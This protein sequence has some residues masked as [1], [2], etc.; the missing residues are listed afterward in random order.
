MLPLVATG[1]LEIGAK[2]ID[3][4]LPDPA[5]QAE[6]KLKLLELQQNG[7]LAQLQADTDLAK[8][9]METNTAE[10]QS[11]SLF[12]AGWRP[13]LG[14]VCG[15]GFAVQFVL[16]PLLSWG[17][18]LYGHPITFPSLDIETMMPMLFG[19]LGLGAYR[20]AEKI[21]GVAAK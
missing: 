7:E 6:A 9:Q 14:W 15:T 18:A 17:S 16:G 8:G 4:I 5:A 21:K 11:G 20:T 3:K 19:M 10:A 1:L 2:L 13:F 12:I